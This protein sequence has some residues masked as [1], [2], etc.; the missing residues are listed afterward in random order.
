MIKVKLSAINRLKKESEGNL[1]LS[2]ILESIF[3]SI[4]K[5][6]KHQKEFDAWVDVDLP[7]TLF[8]RLLTKKKILPSELRF[9]N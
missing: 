4:R 2:I 5:V 1:V 3:N 8:K 7:E 9:Y 6:E